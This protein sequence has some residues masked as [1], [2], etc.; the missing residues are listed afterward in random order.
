MIKDI[1]LYFCLALFCINTY[2]QSIIVDYSVKINKEKRTSV[3]D[4]LDTFTFKLSANK[5][6]SF[7]RLEDVLYVIKPQELY[8]KHFIKTKNKLM[9]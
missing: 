4:I 3:D 9:L 7:F 5:R 8:K 6:E 1:I 2:S